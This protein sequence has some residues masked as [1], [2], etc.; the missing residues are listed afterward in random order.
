M[1]SNFN[2]EIKS[3]SPE[4][5]AATGIVSIPTEWSSRICFPVY[6]PDGAPGPVPE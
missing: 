1:L 5:N 3:C 2:R 6:S 4:A